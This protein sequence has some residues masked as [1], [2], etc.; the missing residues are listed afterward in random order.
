MKHKMKPIFWG[1][2]LICAAAAIILSQM[3][4]LGEVGV[5]T[6]LL[7]V[8]LVPALVYNIIHLDFF[9]IFLPA[10][11]LLT[12][13]KEQIGLQDVNSWYI[14]L[15]AGLLGAGLS[16]IFPRRKR[17]KAQTDNW[18]IFGGDGN[19]R[20]TSESADS[21]FFSEI[22]AGSNKY[23][24]SPNLKRVRARTIFGG[25]NLYFENAV[26]DPNGAV[27]DITCLFG[28]MELYLP[29]DWEITNHATMIFSGINERTPG[30]HGV[31]G[32]PK[33]TLTGYS[34][35]GGVTIYYI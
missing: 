8:L 35:F 13:Y 18:A 9:G 17:S 27:L 12:L 20:G 32:A 15:A 11:I 28:G 30:V 33:L 34:M 21:L 4:Y 19:N 29:R 22:F 5:W 16:L 6:I 10:A 1:L 25:M 31:V 2:L 26:L 7:T 23:I 14:W 24:R 3:G